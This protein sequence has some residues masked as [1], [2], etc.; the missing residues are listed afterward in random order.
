MNSVVST[1]AFFGTL[2]L[3]DFYLGSSLSVSQ[4]IKIYVNLGTPL[5]APQYIKIYVKSFPPPAV[6]SRLGRL[7]VFIK[8]DASGKPYVFF[9]IE[10]ILYGLKEAGK[11]SNLRLVGLLA[12]FGFFETTTP[13]FFRHVSR[14]ISFVLVVDDFGVKYHSKVD[15]DYLVSCLTTLYQVKSHPTGTKFLVFT[16]K[17]DRIPGTLVVSYPGYVASLL[18]RLRPHGV[19]QPRPLLRSQC[20]FAN[21]SCDMRPGVGASC[22]HLG[23]DTPS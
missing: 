4:Y 9:R 8:H 11:L 15:F 2:D 14:P 16:I 22:S 12:S 1:L 23:Y 21:P 5:S 18:A 10:K 3:T 13:G 6:L 17:H 20:G 19:T 7:D